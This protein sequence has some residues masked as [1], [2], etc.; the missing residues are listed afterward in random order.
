MKNLL[1]LKICL[2]FKPIFIY[3]A[4]RNF[5]GYGEIKNK[6]EAT[7][8]TQFMNKQLKS[9]LEAGVLVHSKKASQKKMT[10]AQCAKI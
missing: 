5:L 9:L 10:I 7:E 1:K 8:A 3:Q 4:I 6:S 2:K